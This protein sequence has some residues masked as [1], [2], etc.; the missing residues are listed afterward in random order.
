MIRVN[1]ISI[2]SAELIS[3]WQAIKVFNEKNVSEIVII[4]DSLHTCK[5]LLNKL[6]NYLYMTRWEHKWSYTDKAHE[7]D[8]IV[9]VNGKLVK[10]LPQLPMLYM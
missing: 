1:T 10:I 2:L 9:L 5:A 7:A 6:V 3:L 8:K 4:T